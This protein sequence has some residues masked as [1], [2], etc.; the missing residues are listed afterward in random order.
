ME[1]PIQKVRQSSIVFEKPGYLTETF[2]TFTSSNYLSAEHLLLKFFTRFP[3][4]S[5]YKRV[6]RSF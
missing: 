3:L 6:F 4:T 1:N 2:K 5:V